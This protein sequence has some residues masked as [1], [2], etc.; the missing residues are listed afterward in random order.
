MCARN[1]DDSRFGGDCNELLEHASG[2][3][4]FREQDYRIVTK[5]S[6]LLIEHQNIELVWIPGHSG[7][8]ENK[9]ADKEARNA[10][11]SEIFDD[12]TLE[13][14]DF[15]K[16]LPAYEL[17]CKNRRWKYLVANGRDYLK[18]RRAEDVLVSRVR[19]VN[20]RLTHGYLMVS[21]AERVEPVC[22][23]CGRGLTMTHVLVECDGYEAHRRGLNMGP[24]PVSLLKTHGK[25]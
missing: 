9:K 20:S 13:Y 2:S 15:R 6:I 22:Q 25:F 1:R 17:T 10:A 5:I 24:W 7:L 19:I 23:H 12:T 4:K 18:G 11:N 16:S 14:Q 3:C 8:L 21:T